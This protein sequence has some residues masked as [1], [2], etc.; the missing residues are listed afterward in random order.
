MILTHMFKVKT[1]E[2]KR[3]YRKNW[4]LLKRNT[5]IDTIPSSKEEIGD[6]LFAG[7]LKAFLNKHSPFWTFPKNGKQEEK[8][9]SLTFH[10]RSDE[11]DCG[12][13]TAT[14]R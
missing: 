8:R 5:K 7:K 6:N 13:F 10:Q 4:T 14:S 11:S 1:A 9:E 2:I 12:R 3:M